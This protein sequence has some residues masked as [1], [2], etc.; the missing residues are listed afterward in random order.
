MYSAR[1][2]S[3]RGVTLPGDPVSTVD[4]VKTAQNCALN[5][6]ELYELVLTFNDV[7]IREMDYTAVYHTGFF[8]CVFVLQFCQQPAECGTSSFLTWLVQL[9]FSILL[10]HHISKLSSYSD[11]LPEAS[12]FQHH[13][14]PCS[15]CSIL[16]VS[17]SNLSPIW[18]NQSLILRKGLKLKCNLNRYLVTVITV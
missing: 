14:K 5:F 13:T 4:T 8:V 18:A 1:S 9:I 11:L 12:K 16:L 17:S 6:S 2:C 7:T 10:Q 3:F 15:K